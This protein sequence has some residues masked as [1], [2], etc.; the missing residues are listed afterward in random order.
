[1]RI[2]RL[3]QRIQIQSLSENSKDAHGAPV[4]TWVTDST[5][6]A[7]VRGMS[8]K[9]FLIAD[10]TDSRLTHIIQ[11][12]FVPNL[13]PNNRIIFENRTLNIISVDNLDERNEITVVRATED[14]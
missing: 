11:M 12:R 1:M 2:G 14:S 8:H 13:T 7:W 6:W 3:R 9:E 10:R 5:R 4:K